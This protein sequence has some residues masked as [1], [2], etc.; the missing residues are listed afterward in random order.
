MSTQGAT[1][2]QSPARWNFRHLLAAFLIGFLLQS[3]FLPCL[4]AIGDAKIALA[5]SFDGLVALRM[6]WAYF[7][8][9][10]GKG[11]IAYAVLCYTSVVWIEGITYLML[12][13]N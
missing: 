4:C 9:E 11:W 2:I 10:T 13:E 3:L 5:Y 1:I 12:G 7:R 6:L 8:R